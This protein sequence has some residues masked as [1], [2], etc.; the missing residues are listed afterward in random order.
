MVRRGNYVFGLLLLATTAFAGLPEQF[1]K[2]PDLPNAVAIV[3][4]A[5]VRK[6]AGSG[7]A[8]SKAQLADLETELSKEIES[9]AVAARIDIDSLE[10]VWEV[11]LAKMPKVPPLADLAKIEGGYV[12]HFGAREVAWSQRNLYLF[13]PEET[14]LVMIRP[15]NRQLVSQWMMAIDTGDRKGIGTYLAE[16]V[17]IATDDG[18]PIVM[19]IDLRGALSPVQIKEKL[20]HS[21]SASKR[22]DLDRLAKLIAGIRGVVFAADFGA[23][24]RGKIRIDFDSPTQP[25][26]SIAKPLVL[27][28]FSNCGIYLDDFADWHEHI[29][30][31]S[32]SLSGKLSAGG[33]LGVMSI[34]RTPAATA[35]V[36][37][38]AASVDLS[39]RHAENGHAAATKNYYDGVRQN[40]KKVKE[41]SAKTFGEKAFFN[42]RCAQRIDD[43]PL[44]QVDD[45]MIEYGSEVAKLLRG[46]SLAIREAGTE[47]GRKKAG[48]KRAYYSSGT[49]S[50]NGGAL[51]ITT[52]VNVANPAIAQASAEATA[53][54]A[55]AHIRNLQAIDEMTAEIRRKMT[56]KYKIEF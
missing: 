5:A 49:W 38:A 16:A 33:I 14:D 10:P 9:V 1:A 17:K 35:T 32:I 44:L 12:D 6:A 39:S 46:A 40:I 26:A 24:T 47:S 15:A 54:S 36:S 53:K 4:V 28:A 22:K 50:P 19:A 18:E 30:D 42:E 21:P 8:K 3:N 27:E 51:V 48:M 45:E 55:T 13:R 25:L 31:K 56:S 52:G 43:L 7:D 2:L 37:R 29:G 20:S 34:L 11:A 23:T 41:F